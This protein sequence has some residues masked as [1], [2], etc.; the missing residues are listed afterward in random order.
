MQ[1]TICDFCGDIIKK[2]Y[3][4]KR[5][6]DLGFGDMIVY[7]DEKGT[8]TSLDLCQK[9]FVAALFTGAQKAQEELEKEEKGE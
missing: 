2:P 4:F 3:I 5:T 6:I 7:I 8:D 9:C 1:A